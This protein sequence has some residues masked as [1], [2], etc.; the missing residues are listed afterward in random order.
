MVQDTFIQAFENLDKLSAPAKFRPWI[1]TIARNMSINYINRKRPT[2]FSEMSDEEDYDPSLRFEDDH[3]ENLP[4]VVIDRKETTRLMREI[5]DSLSE[6]QRL[7]V[8][9]FYYQDMS[10]RRIA[11]RL[12]VSENTVKSRLFQGRKKIE[13]K[14]K[15]LEKQGTKL[16]SVSPIALLLLLYRSQD[17]V[18][19]R[20]PGEELFAEITKE[21]STGTVTAGKAEAVRQTAKATAKHSA[22]KTTAGAA[23]KSAGAGIATK[24]IAAVAAVVVLGGGGA[25][26][27]NHVTNQRQAQV[28]PT[29]MVEAFQPA[30]A[31]SQDMET[32]IPAVEVSNEAAHTAYEALLDDYRRGIAG[33]SVESPLIAYDFNASRDYY[34]SDAAE[35]TYERLEFAFFDLNNDGIDEMIF[36]LYAYY[37]PGVEIQFPE[38]YT[39]DGSRVVRLLNGLFITN[40]LDDGQLMRMGMNYGAIDLFSL[41]AHGTEL[42]HTG[43]Y[44]QENA[45]FLSEEQVNERFLAH[46]A[47]LNYTFVLTM[48]AQG[49]TAPVGVSQTEDYTM[50]SGTWQYVDGWAGTMPTE[51]LVLTVNADNTIAFDFSRYRIS[52]I[53]DVQGTLDPSTG[54]ASFNDGYNTGT[55]TFASGT[56][57]FR[58]DH[59]GFPYTEDGYEVLF[60]NSGTAPIHAGKPLS[61]QELGR[62]ADYVRQNNFGERSVFT[63]YDV[64]GDG[65]REMLSIHGVRDNY[66]DIYMDIYTLQNEQVTL[67][68]QSELYKEAGGPGWSMLQVQMQ[69]QTYLALRYFQGDGQPSTEYILLDQMLRVAHHIFVQYDYNYDTNQLTLR[70]ITLDGTP[71]SASG[72]QDL[73]TT[74]MDLLVY[75]T[76]S[77]Y[78]APGQ[79][80]YNQL[81]NG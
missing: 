20:M 53:Y 48:S 72:I 15:D 9:L 1:K 51:T 19:A 50:Y 56:I 32:V 45:E 76:D 16:Y 13:S 49:G 39:F 37:N 62:Y 61:A 6:D 81:V 38:V 68:Y 4:D 59:S 64:D 77:N 21:L 66:I 11:E 80:S 60:E 43:A 26:V 52:G 58:F 63:F 14:V 25:V 12:G 74:Q 41:P 69:G 23:A 44:R 42:E 70:E 27:A 10:I 31:D 28:E 40:V 33:E 79:L 35:G 7:V 30:P 29:A 18:S 65:M 67:L 8:G 73:F 78:M 71:V 46:E 75:T 57:L 54:V 36:R 24:V 3:L 2:L 47:A 5:L 34:S 22:V 17:A 55:L